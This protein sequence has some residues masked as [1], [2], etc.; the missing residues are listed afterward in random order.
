MRVARPGVGVAAAP[1]RAARFQDGPLSIRRKRHSAQVAGGIR[2][3]AGAAEDGFIQLRAVALRQDYDYG[4]WLC[5]RRRP[6][7]DVDD[8]RRNVGSR[9]TCLGARRGDPQVAH[10]RR[11][12]HGAGHLRPDRDLVEI[13]DRWRRRRLGRAAARGN[14]HSRRA[15]QKEPPPFATFGGHSTSEYPSHSHGPR[16]RPPL[17]VV[18]TLPP[19]PRFHLRARHATEIVVGAPWR[20]QPTEAEGR[21]AIPGRFRSTVTKGLKSSSCGEPAEGNDCDKP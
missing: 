13:E 9:D 1:R 19:A 12:G 5:R 17:H 10:T 15:T 3:G 7:G 16:V 14:G 2:D 20:H 6:P 21:R 11:R 8:G 4:D 18:R